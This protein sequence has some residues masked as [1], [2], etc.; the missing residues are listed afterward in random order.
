[1]LISAVWQSDL[2][3]HTYIHTLFKIFSIMVYHR[4]LN[5]VLVLHSKPLSVIH[6]THRCLHLL[7]RTSYSIRP[8]IPSPWANTSL[9]SMSEI[10]PV[11]SL[12]LRFSF[13]FIVRFIC[14]AQFLIVS[15]LRF[16]SPLYWNHFSKGHCSKCLLFLPLLKH[17]PC[18]AS[19]FSP[20]YPNYP[21]KEAFPFPFS[22][23]EIYPGWS[24]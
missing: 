20:D 23:Y 15:M 11:C 13:C 3:I 2:V 24:V 18:P 7:T 1:M 14:H 10:P 9:F 16:L 6:P 8:P 22:T 17:W 5:I 21:P 4:I 12:C 19:Q